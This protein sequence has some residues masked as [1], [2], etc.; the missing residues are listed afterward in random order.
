MVLI[1]NVCEWAHPAF[2]EI[3]DLYDNPR[4]DDI[5]SGKTDLGG[6]ISGTHSVVFMLFF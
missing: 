4:S 1:F 3:N 6:W 2:K 5:M